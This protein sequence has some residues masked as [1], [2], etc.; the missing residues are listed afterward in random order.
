MVISEKLLNELQYLNKETESILLSNSL[1]DIQAE[2]F[3][4]NLEK[5][6]YNIL[7]EIKQYNSNTS[8]EYEKVKTIDNEY[9]AEILDNILKIYVPETMISYK[10]LKTH[11]YKRIL[12]NVS[13]ITKKFNGIFQGSVFIFI[14]IFDNITGWDIDNKYVTP[15]SDALI[16]SGVIQDDNISKM[17]YSVK[18]EFSDTPHT[19]IYVTDS[20]KIDNYLEKSIVKKCGNLK[21]FQI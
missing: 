10:N 8:Y 20:K 12:L 19:E 4:R 1:T 6:R 11:T 18:G 15:I 2:T 5:R 21:N 7:S 13:E 16:S 9:K 14:K 3:F 17:F